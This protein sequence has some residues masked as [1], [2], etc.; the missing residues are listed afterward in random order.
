MA[1]LKCTRSE[2]P[3]GKNRTCAT[4]RLAGMTWVNTDFIKPHQGVAL[5]RYRQDFC[6]LVAGG[7]VVT[8]FSNRDTNEKSRQE[9]YFIL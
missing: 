2:Q 3:S 1:I 5:A 7:L 4:Y 8:P 6:V 9:L